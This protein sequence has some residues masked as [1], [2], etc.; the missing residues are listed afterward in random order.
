MTGFI[1]LRRGLKETWIYQDAIALGV[2]TYLLSEAEFQDRTWIQGG[3]TIELQRGQLIT[4]RKKIA[5]HFNLHESRIERVLKKLVQ[6]GVIEQ[7]TNRNYRVITI[8]KYDS[9]DETELQSNFK[10]DVKQVT[11]IGRAH[12]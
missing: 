10:Q 8:S 6:G 7:Q 4:G 2:F 11:K 12:V 1:K 5:T 3:K 9:C